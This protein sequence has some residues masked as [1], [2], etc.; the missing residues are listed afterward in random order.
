[1]YV[2]VCTCR[3]IC[4]TFVSVIVYGSAEGECSVAA[5]N[6][7]LPLISDAR[8]FVMV[9]RKLVICQAP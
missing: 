1:M 6:N 7:L 8:G 2:Y 3:P 9:G 4:N 5:V